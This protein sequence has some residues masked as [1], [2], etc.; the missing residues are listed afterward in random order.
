M[1][2]LL[3]TFLSMFT[4]LALA[5]CE[6]GGSSGS[7]TGNTDSETDSTNDTSKS[8]DSDT[9]KTK[10]TDSYDTSIDT[11]AG[12]FKECADIPADIDVKPINLLVLL[13]RSGSMAKGK[14]TSGDTYAT[15]V[16][17]AIDAIVQQNTQSGIINFALNVFPSAE[18]CTNVYRLSH[19]GF[20]TDGNPDPTEPSMDLNT[21]CEATSNFLWPT[22]P[23]GTAPVA[24]AYN[25]PNV[26][27]SDSVTMDTYTAISD[28][29]KNVGQCGGTPICQSLWWA[30]EYLQ[31]VNSDNA[32]YILLA[33][34]GAPSCSHS[35][36]PSTCK[37]SLVGSSQPTY[38]EQCLDDFCSINASFYL[39]AK[40]YKLFVVGVG[41]EAKEFE[42][43][44]DAM[45]YFGG[46][47][48]NVCKKDATNPYEICPT[49]ASD[50][51]GH[52]YFPA[53]NANDLSAALEDITNTALSCEFEVP[54]DN[55]PDYNPDDTEKPVAKKCDMVKAK[56]VVSSWFADTDT[57][58]D[59]ETDT[60][61]PN[62]IRYD[63]SCKEENGHY[64]WRWADD[65]LIGQPWSVV[66]AEK[67]IANC[68]KIKLCPKACENLQV[69]DGKRIWESVGASFGC[70]PT[71]SID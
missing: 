53:A 39:A 8:T 41:D 42:A 52:W 36:N 70:Q 32:T 34:D 50:A 38:S 24:S 3:L 56:A 37:T 4:L 60:A 21:A 46:G 67:D 65:T 2:R 47:N 57:S 9:D 30:Y 49:P 43:V 17:E 7:N 48:G 28:A 11:D 25:D 14:V 58:V 6:G 27:F 63:P 1:G 5:G 71:V 10:S 44:L 19:D 23:I 29:L 18:N 22:A 55:V 61:D 16:Q 26:E 54:W 66:E 15:V 20:D 31:S 69:H 40:Q 62:E 33:T 68:T 12:N 59:T 45:A 64:G 35:L 13:D 51:D